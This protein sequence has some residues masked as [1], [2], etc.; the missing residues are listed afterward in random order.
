[1]PAL[2]IR[3][4]SATP[5]FLTLMLALL[6]G[7]RHSVITHEEPATELPRVKLRRPLVASITSNANAD[8]TRIADLCRQSGYFSVIRDEPSDDDDVEIRFD[9]L[10]C[11]ETWELHGIMVPLSG[12]LQLV[13]LG[14][15]PIRK[16][17][18][19]CDVALGYRLTRDG[20]ERETPY[21]Y[22]SDEY[23]TIIWTPLYRSKARV[24][25]QDELLLDHAVAS[26]LSQ[27]V[28]ELEEQGW[29]GRRE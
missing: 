21:A 25:Y 24:K 8:T 18:A 29:D 5:V 2:L 17:K 22:K 11:V 27:L 19:K 23:S 6:A 26:M 7:C 20:S 10:V 16:S 1:M 14:L 4:R 3:H 13:T 12:L 15:A 9:G 28:A